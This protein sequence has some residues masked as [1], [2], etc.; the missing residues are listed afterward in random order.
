MQTGPMGPPNPGGIN[1][2]AGVNPHTMK[3]SP[4]MGMGNPVQQQQQQQQGIY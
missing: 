1:S 3:G 4:M 2:L